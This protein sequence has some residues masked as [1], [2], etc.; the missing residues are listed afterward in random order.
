[1]AYSN[2]GILTFPPDALCLANETVDKHSCLIT[3]EMVTFLNFTQNYHVYFQAYC[4]NPPQYDGCPYGYCPNADVG[5]SLVRI[6]AY[7]TNF[8]VA[9]IILY[10]KEVPKDPIWSQMLTVYSLLIACAISILRKELSRIH[11][12]IAVVIASSPTS[13]Y[14][15][16]YAIRSIFWDGGRMKAAFGDKRIVQRVVAIAALPFWIALAAYT[17]LPKNQSSFTQISCEQ[18]LGWG[19]FK[20]FLFLPFVLYVWVTEDTG[21]LG[22]VL[23]ALPIE[24]IVLSWF[25]AILRSRRDIWTRGERFRF[26]FRKVWDTIAERYPFIL[27]LSMVIVPSGYW[28]IVIEFGASDSQDDRWSLTFGQVLTM[29][30]TIPPIIEAWGLVPRIIPWF[31][32]LTWVRLLTCRSR[33]TLPA[34]GAEF[35]LVRQGGQ[36]TTAYT[37]LSGEDNDG[38]NL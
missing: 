28:V 27:F 23:L 22:H 14:I 26:R 29:F 31:I 8:L 18:A 36:S 38:R 12:I 2:S 1:M 5:G 16:I 20:E 4:L 35:P 19:E 37:R 21:V 7:L 11:A 3:P 33:P 6:S 15:L 30:V 9:T 32:D 10:N 25:I 24:I 34:A 17:M 13:V